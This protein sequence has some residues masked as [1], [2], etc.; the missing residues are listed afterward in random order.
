MAEFRS[1]GRGRGEM[2]RVSKVGV[3]YAN[4]DTEVPA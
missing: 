3:A 2:K 1:G 4:V